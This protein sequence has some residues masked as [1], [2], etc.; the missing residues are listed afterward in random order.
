MKV[1]TL[2][3]LS[4]F[5]AGIISL[6]VVV[7]AETYYVNVQKIPK[8]WEDKFGDV[9]Y[10]ATKYWEKR[11]SGLK[12]Y[13]VSYPHQSDFVVT[14]A[15]QYTEGKLG[16]YTTNTDND[17]GKPY[18]AITLGYMDDESVKW[19]KR[20]FNLVSREYVI[21]ITKHELGHAIG[22]PHSS[23]PND[24]M[25]PSIYNYEEWQRSHSGSSLGNQKTSEKSKVTARLIITETDWKKESQKYQKQT[26]TKI[27]VLKVGIQKAED[28]LHSTWHENSQAQAEVEKAWT[29]LWWA[30]KYLRDAEWTQKEGKTFVS[31]SKYKEAYY[32]YKYSFDS[33]KKIES[34]LLEITKYLNNADSIAYGK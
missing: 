12:F 4:I 29:A 7:L 26:D 1:I 5:L 16:Y 8:H 11:I 24:I 3:V 33:S 20:K 32:K 14:W 22:F 9:L 27:S 6:P 21:E 28:A 2:V 13:S 30:K 17:Y 10:Q 18:I 25:Y 15:S 31:Q 34:Y 19:Q 23:D